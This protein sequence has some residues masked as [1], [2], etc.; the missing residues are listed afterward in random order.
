MEQ[1]YFTPITFAGCNKDILNKDN[2]KQAYAEY[3]EECKESLKLLLAEAG[4]SH[5]FIFPNFSLGT[6]LGPQGYV[7]EIPS[8]KLFS[9]WLFTQPL[10]RI[11]SFFEIIANEEIVI[12]FK[13]EETRDKIRKSFPIETINYPNLTDVAEGNWSPALGSQGSSIGIYSF[14][15][16]VGNDQVE[17]WF[18]GVHS[19]LHYQTNKLL[20][21]ALT[22][23]S[24]KNYEM[25]HRAG[26]IEPGEVLK[27]EKV[28]SFIHEGLFKRM[29]NISREN[30]KKLATQ[31]AR[32]LK[33]NFKTDTFASIASLRTPNLSSHIFDTSPALVKELLNWWPKDVDLF[34]DSVVL[35]D[36]DEENK[37]PEI[38]KR[39]SISKELE[40]APVGVIFNNLKKKAVT[41]NMESVLNQYKFKCLDKRET[42]APV[43]ECDYNTFRIYN[44]NLYYYNNCTSTLP[45]IHEPALAVIKQLSLTQGYEI[46]NS[47][48]SLNNSSL[49]FE[50]SQKW[51]NDFGNA[52]PVIFPQM[53]RPDISAQ[54][55][56]DV[57]NKFFSLYNSINKEKDKYPK[58]IKY[59]PK[60]RQKFEEP[61]FVKDLQPSNFT[62]NVVQFT[63]EFVYLGPDINFDSSRSIEENSY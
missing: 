41:E 47:K 24:Y 18:I 25:T 28:G 33:L 54:N 46:I 39:L 34:L 35:Y 6:L 38:V 51:T 15:E 1:N 14:K 8:T 45:D 30:N 53:K 50:Q 12:G 9:S 17:R 59:V 3:H 52:Y 19:G 23:I 10:F 37:D 62:P 5:F 27:L 13:N 21:D 36:V 16:N 49:H 42:V 61:M 48:I 44:N 22:N 55:S 31:F 4:I 7:A 26:M 58:Q 32:I 56:N 40:N 43:A 11:I 29:R 2:E 20:L 57:F 63:P 60:Y